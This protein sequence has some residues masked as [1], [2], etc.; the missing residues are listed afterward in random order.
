MPGKTRTPA[1][2]MFTPPRFNEA[3]AKCRGKLAVGGFRGSGVSRFNEAPAKC[4]GKQ[5]DRG[6]E[7]KGIGALQ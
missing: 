5:N 6:A 7:R 3:P 2:R 1:C 4:R